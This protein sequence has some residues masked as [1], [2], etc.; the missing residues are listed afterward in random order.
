MV[1]S[2]PTCPLG[3]SR[4]LLALMKPSLALPW[5]LTWCR[6]HQPTLA[7]TEVWLGAGYS[8]SPPTP[9]LLLRLTEAALGWALACSSACTWSQSETSGPWVVTGEGGSSRGSG[10]ESSSTSTHTGRKCF[11]CSAPVLRLYLFDSTCIMSE[12]NRAV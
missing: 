10:P 5:L 1:C 6:L 3:S 11:F 7:A 8:V 9:W 12:Y 2:S 4:G